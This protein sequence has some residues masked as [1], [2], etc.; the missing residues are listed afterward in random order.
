MRR[1]G[2]IAA[3]V[4]VSFALVI[5]S[6]WATITPVKVVVLPADQWRAFGSA[7][8]V[9]FASTSIAHPNH[10]DAL[11]VHRAT[12]TSAPRLNAAGT[13]GFP[14]G[15]DP[16]TNT[17]IYQQVDGNASDLYYFNL[18]TRTRTK[19]PGVNTGSWEWGPRISSSYVMFFRDYK[20]SGVWNTGLYLWDRAKKIGRLIERYP[21]SKKVSLSAGSV[22]DRYASWTR[23]A[24]SCTVFL[25][26]TTS[27]DV[28]QVPTKGSRPQ[29]APVIDEAN[30]LIFFARSGFGCGIEVAFWSL[31]LS[32]LAATPTKIASLPSGVD[33]D[34]SASLMPSSGGTENDLLFSR[35]VCGKAGDIWALPGVSP[36]AP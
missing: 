6:A 26:D 11:A 29:Y 8:Y 35:A 10:V 33:T 3:A 34:S 27:R 19:V 32:D 31:P 15:F 24:A 28:R 9:V 22:G 14:G 21:W 25:Y 12:G 30:D 7:T 36:L 2:F 16:G 20:V 23:C 4:V 5:T 17:A 13:V 18:D 1:I